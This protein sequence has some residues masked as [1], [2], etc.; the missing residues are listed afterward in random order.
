MRLMISVDWVSRTAREGRERWEGVMVV[1]WGDIGDERI[2][3]RES[4]LKM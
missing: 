4:L 3:M 1:G 2:C